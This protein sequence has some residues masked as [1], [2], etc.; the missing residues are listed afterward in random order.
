MA[1]MV[2]AFAAVEPVKI[3]VFRL[4]TLLGP[5]FTTG[6]VIGCGVHFMDSSAFFTKNGVF[7]GVAFKD[8]K[9]IGKVYPTVGLRSLILR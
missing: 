7:L 6:D 2:I 1:T 5:S 4:S 8:L 9:S 3:T